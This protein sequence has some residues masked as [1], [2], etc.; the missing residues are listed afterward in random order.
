M[1]IALLQPDVVD[2]DFEGNS[3]KLAALCASAAG[4]KLC[5]APAQAITGP[6]HARC[7]VSPDWQEQAVRLGRDL[8]CRLPDGQ[9]LL[10]A[11]PGLG[12][13]LLE[14]R[15]VLFLG[16]IFTFS[17][18]EIGMD[19][20]PENPSPADLC[21]HLDSRPFA[22]G[23]QNEWELL[24]SGQCRQQGRAALAVNLAG[25][26]GGVIYNGQSVCVDKKGDVTA[27]GAA[28][29]EDVLVVDTDR[30]LAGRLEPCEELLAAQWQALRLGVTDFFAKTGAR[31]AVLGLSGGM[32]S[33]LVACIAA[34]ALGAENV[35]GLLLPSPYT[36]KAS[37]DDA[38][39][40]AAN[41]EIR[42]FTLAIDSLFSECGKTLSPVFAQVEAA[43]GELTRENL[44]ARLRGLLLMAF[45]NWTGAL[46]LNTGNKSESAMGYCTLYGDTAGAIAVIGD[47]FKTQVYELARWY[48]RQAG[49][50]IIPENIFTKAPSA[51][52]RPNQKDTDSLPP[53]VELDGTL[54]SL[55]RGEK[56]HED[57]GRLVRSQEFKRR[58]SPPPLLVSGLP[59]SGF[60]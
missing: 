31:K 49:A 53:Y 4:A 30:E 16:E 38:L 42:T 17:G 41:L 47:L 44:Q 27:R 60:C 8:A 48:C 45:A 51:E 25:G 55:L 20:S 5:V 15:D 26:Y 14:N 1:K 50:M 13:A 56:G 57:L 39:E 11:L 3:R 28:F 54:K 7:A 52:L 32:D 2:N 58:Q 9:A 18:L 37:I 34:D 29:A 59:L 19:L 21:I 40:L 33:A 46:V 10:T 12:P 36:S 6:G 43:P 23:M 35:T 22:P 24:L